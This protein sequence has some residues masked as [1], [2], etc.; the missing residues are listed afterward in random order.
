MLIIGDQIAHVIIMLS[1]HNTGVIDYTSLGKNVSSW[2]ICSSLTF[3]P[4][5]LS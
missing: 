5:T 4:N 3:V 1:V 2:S